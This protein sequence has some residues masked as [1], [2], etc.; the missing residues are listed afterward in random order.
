MKYAISFTSSG[1]TRFLDL[2]NQMIG[3][4]LRVLI[5]GPTL[6]DTKIMSAVHW[7]IEL[8]RRTWPWLLIFAL[9]AASLASVEVQRSHVRHAVLRE[10]ESQFHCGRGWARA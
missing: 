7:T 9:P 8:M 1:N 10:R 4:H 2:L 3:I 5:A 6:A